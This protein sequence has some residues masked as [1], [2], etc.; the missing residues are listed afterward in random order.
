MTTFDAVVIGGGPAGATTALALA[1]RGRRVALCEATGGDGA[2][3][4]E[5]LPPEINPLLKRLGLWEPFVR[6]GHLESPGIVSVWGTSER[7]ESDFVRNVHGCGWHLDRRRFDAMI[8]R[9][10]VDAGVTAMHGARVTACR[11]P[12]SEPWSLTVRGRAPR[13]VVRA[14]VVVDASGRAG[15]R[16]GDAPR[17]HV[18]DRL[19]AVVMR[20][21]HADPPPDLRTY[22]E[23]VSSGWWYSSP[24][25]GGES[26][27]MFFTDRQTYLAEAA[28]LASVLRRSPLTRP[29]FASA[30]VLASRVLYAP[31]AVRVDPV[32]EAHV[33]VGD[34]AAAYDPLSGRG[35]FK[36]L[37]DGLA[38]ADAVHALLAGERDPLP[39]YADRVRV[40]FGAYSRQR[41]A[42]YAEEAR[43]P[44]AP[45]WRRRL[46][47]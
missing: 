30:R 15:H 7:H 16:L 22:I 4:G 34:S 19:L 17:F 46:S 31:S 27:A 26:M 43:W 47:A 20:L 38:A 37:R 1:R 41:R 32:G 11:R 39:A 24:L 44:D 13:P 18:E 2:R 23:A 5:T 10:A 29:R 28:D 12:A 3:Y 42:Y 6:D 14:E 33:A 36:A 9:A 40:E 35:I 8:L 25:P 21:G 45:F